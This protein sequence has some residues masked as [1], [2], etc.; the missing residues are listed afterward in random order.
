MEI[1]E[2]GLLHVIDLIADFN[3]D[4]G[5]YKER[6]RVLERLIKAN[7]G[8]YISLTDLCAIFDIEAPKCEERKE[9]E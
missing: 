2:D 6:E 8:S 4:R 7:G 1:S 5:V 3:Y 9:Q